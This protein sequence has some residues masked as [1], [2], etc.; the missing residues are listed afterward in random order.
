MALVIDTPSS[1]TFQ[2]LNQPPRNE[3]DFSIFSVMSAYRE[4]LDTFLD[5]RG[6]SSICFPSSS[7][8]R[9]S[10]ISSMSSVSGRSSRYPGCCVMSV[11]LSM[12]LSPS[13]MHTLTDSM[14]RYQILCGKRWF[15]WTV[16]WWNRSP[17]KYK[18]FNECD[19]LKLCA[20]KTFWINNRLF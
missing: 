3:M 17:C 1:I 6:F 11:N 15:Q 8:A 5:T 19:R 2:L 4:Y 12:V 14:G 20:T 9:W 10:S 13:Y 18:R 16:G 7:F